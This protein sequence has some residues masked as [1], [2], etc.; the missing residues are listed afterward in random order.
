MLSL[1]RS[2]H[3]RVTDTVKCRERRYPSEGV[4]HQLTRDPCQGSTPCGCTNSMSSSPTSQDPPRWR[5]STCPDDTVEPRARGSQG[6]LTKTSSRPCISRGRPPLVDK[7][8]DQQVHPDHPCTTLFSK[9]HPTTTYGQ[10]P[11]SSPPLPRTP[12]ALPRDPLPDH[13]LGEGPQPTTPGQDLSPATP[14]G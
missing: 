6:T 11:L 8:P 7:T 14:V 4:D 3:E 1:W 2:V 13:P 10:R 9:A 12:E 5:V